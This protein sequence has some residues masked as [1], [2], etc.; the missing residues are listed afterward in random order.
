MWVLWRPHKCANV[1]PKSYVDPMWI[2]VGSVWA[3]VGM[4]AGCLCLY[5]AFSM[6]LSTCSYVGLCV[7]LIVALSFNLPLCFTQCIT[8][9]PFCPTNLIL[10]RS[11]FTT[12]CNRRWWSIV[13]APIYLHYNPILLSLSFSLPFSVHRYIRR[14]STSRSWK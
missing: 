2:Y 4:F 3:Y 6:C 12:F 9:G 11:Y 14:C 10:S 13:I 1:G 8:V 5:I 7:R